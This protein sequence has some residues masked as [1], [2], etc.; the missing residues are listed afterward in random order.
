MLIDQT[1]IE[2]LIGV[3]NL[4]SMSNGGG[5]E[6]SVNTAAVTLVITQAEAEIRKYMIDRYDWPLVFV[7]ETTG[8]KDLLQRICFDI[9]HYYLSSKKYSDEEMKNTAQR[10]RSA[11]SDLKLIQ[12]GSIVLDDVTMKSKAL[13]TG[14][15]IKD[16]TDNRIFG[17]DDWQKI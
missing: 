9:A 10:Y 5:N 3:P 2:T 6:D 13:D 7:S 12:V 14:L 8:S 17:T 16:N 15:V 4:Q 11:K 1:Y